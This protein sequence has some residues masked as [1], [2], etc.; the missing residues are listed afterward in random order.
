M[1]YYIVFSC[2]MI[3]WHGCQRDHGL[4]KVMFWYLSAGSEENHEIHLGQNSLF[5]G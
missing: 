2:R 4:T 3:N 5:R 1:S